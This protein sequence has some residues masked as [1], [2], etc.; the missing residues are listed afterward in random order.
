MYL[1]NKKSS[2]KYKFPTFKFPIFKFPTS[3]WINNWNTNQINFKYYNDH[4]TISKKIYMIVVEE[5]ENIEDIKNVFNDLN[6][7]ILDK[8]YIENYLIYS[9]RTTDEV[10]NYIKKYNWV[11]NISRGI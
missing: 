10:I 3:K 1:F 4:D 2:T 6:I 9:I 5:I 7:D 8:T 11:V